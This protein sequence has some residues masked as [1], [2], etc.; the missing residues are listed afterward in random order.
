MSV[1][2]PIESALVVGGCGVLG[3]R[4]VTEL[5][6]L[7]PSPKIAVFDLRTAQ[8]R[9]QSPFVEYHDVDITDKEAVRA[10]LRTVRPQ[11]ILHTASPPAGLLDL[12]LYL[13]VN[14][15]GTR[16]LL[17]GAKVG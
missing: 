6:K 5:L 9:V 10:A 8:N 7:D 12:G 11:V 4:M 14:V 2:P 16:N 3:R 13:K 15:E 1:P 17:E